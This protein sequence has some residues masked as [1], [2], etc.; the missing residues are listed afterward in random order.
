MKTSELAAKIKN[1]GTP[2]YEKA[3]LIEEFHLSMLKEHGHKDSRFD[4]GWSQS[5]TASMLKVSKSFV[6]QAIYVSEFLRMKP[7]IQ[8][9]YGSIHDAY[10]GERHAK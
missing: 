6:C 4:D 7:R 5:L 9:E 8:F 1:R 3:K 10:A 2:W